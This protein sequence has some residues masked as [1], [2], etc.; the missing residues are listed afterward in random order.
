M[1][2]RLVRSLPLIIILIVIAIIIYLVVSYR[3]SP[4]RAKEILIR[5]FLVISIIITAFFGLVSLY[6]WSEH[7][8]YVLEL[9]FAFFVVGAI[10]LIITLICR[11]VF[12][13]HHPSYKHKPMKTRKLGG[14]WD[15]FTK[16][17]RQ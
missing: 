13:R 3:R 7:N 5:V 12:L 4:N 11:A 17:F 8:V 2:A 9:M 10:C 1:I 16:F 15:N 14:F 6:A